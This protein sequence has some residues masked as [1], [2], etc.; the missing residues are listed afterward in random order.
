MYN[1]INDREADL[2]V[3][4]LK[5]ILINI[6]WDD[7]IVQSVFIHGCKIEN[8]RKIFNLHETS[9]DFVLFTSCLGEVSSM[10]DVSPY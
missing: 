3:Q 6:F 9:A 8:D 4:I 5:N 10:F 7:V 2:W 1:I